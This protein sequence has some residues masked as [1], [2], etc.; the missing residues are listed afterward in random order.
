MHTIIKE[1]LYTQDF[2]NPINRVYIKYSESSQVYDHRKTWHASLTLMLLV[3]NF[4]NDA[5]KSLKIT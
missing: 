2:L 5:K 3:A 4:A 1:I